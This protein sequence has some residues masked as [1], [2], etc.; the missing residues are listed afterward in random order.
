MDSP[1]IAR[2]L[3]DAASHFRAAY[4]SR[5]VRIIL[6]DPRD[7]NARMQFDVPADSQSKQVKSDR[8]KLTTNRTGDRQI[9]AVVGHEPIAVKAL[10][11]KLRRKLDSH[12]YA[13]L[14][15]LCAGDPPLLIKTPEGFR[16]YK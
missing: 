16:R 8:S 1:A 7:H 3:R 4:G 12:F 2:W 11:H 5:R 13:A 9:Y 15:R 14:R 6:Y 10:A